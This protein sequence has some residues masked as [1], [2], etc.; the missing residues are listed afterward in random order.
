MALLINDAVVTLQKKYDGYK[1]CTLHPID[2]VNET[3]RSNTA[4]KL[5]DR[6]LDDLEKISGLFEIKNSKLQFDN[7]N[8]LINNRT[9]RCKYPVL[10]IV[11]HRTFKM[12]S[13]IHL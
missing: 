2:E 12:S 13:I 9:I 7:V 10:I 6:K 1:V 11:V 3:V 5:S 4:P 8:V